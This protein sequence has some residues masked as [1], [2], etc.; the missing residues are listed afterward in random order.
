MLKAVG[1]EGIFHNDC[2]WHESL[3]RDIMGAVG[4]SVNKKLALDDL[5]KMSPS[6]RH[7]RETNH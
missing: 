7:E 4:K 3:T 2:S 5:D 6:L 1:L